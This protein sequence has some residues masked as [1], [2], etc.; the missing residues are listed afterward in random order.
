[1]ATEKLFHAGWAVGNVTEHSEGARKELVSVSLIGDSTILF[2]P[3]DARRIAQQLLDCADAA[4]A[5]NG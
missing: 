3:A 1:M 2:N 4:E 5:Q